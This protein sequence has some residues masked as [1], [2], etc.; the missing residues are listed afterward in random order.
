M[1]RS[2][3]K[4]KC[5]LVKISKIA[6]GLMICF[7]IFSGCNLQPVELKR[8]EN[9]QLLQF[10][11]KGAVVKVTARINNPNKLKFKVSADDLKLYINKNET[12][13]VRF[14]EKLKI[15]PS[16][17]QSYTFVLESE[18]SAGGGGL[19]ALLSTLSSKKMSLNIKGNLK[20][21]SWGLSKTYPIDISQNVSSRDFGF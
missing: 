16:C 3:M 18:P 5:K 4:S 15:A 6:L 9:V 8:V 10:N 14:R 13:K 2:M 1:F 7:L 21:S 12:G 19:M 11:E 17:E 20:A